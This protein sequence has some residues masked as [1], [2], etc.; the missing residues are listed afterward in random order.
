MNFVINGSKYLEKQRINISRSEALLMLG[1]S[2]LLI[3]E[4]DFEAA[5]QLHNV[6]VRL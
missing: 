6:Y 4:E 3:I 2:W 5:D 1:D